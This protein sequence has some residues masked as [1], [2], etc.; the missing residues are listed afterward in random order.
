[1]L[2]KKI[3]FSLIWKY[4]LID[5]LTGFFNNEFYNN[6]V[7]KIDITF[8]QLNSLKNRNVVIKLS[9]VPQKLNKN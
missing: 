8:F 1:M 3:V 9:T 4:V 6:A 2:Y 7:F 5:H